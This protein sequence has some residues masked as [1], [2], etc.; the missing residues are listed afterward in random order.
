[1]FSEKLLFVEPVA[2]AF[3]NLI[4]I[5]LHLPVHIVGGEEVSLVGKGRIGLHEIICRG[6]RVHAIKGTDKEPFDLFVITCLC[7]IGGSKSEG[8]EGILHALSLCVCNICL[9][10]GDTI[11]ALIGLNPNGGGVALCD[12]GRHKDDITIFS[13]VARSLIPAAFFRPSKLC[14]TKCNGKFLLF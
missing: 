14:R 1:M 11:A 13:T 5:P 9:R 4:L 12:F 10:N 3:G 8:R 2:D 6:F 7:R